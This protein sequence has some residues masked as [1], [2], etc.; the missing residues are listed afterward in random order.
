MNDIQKYQINIIKLGAMTEDKVVLIITIQRNWNV[1]R[2]KVD[3]FQKI[4]NIFGYNNPKKIRN[5]F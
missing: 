5:R 3:Q 1:N 2:I 4:R